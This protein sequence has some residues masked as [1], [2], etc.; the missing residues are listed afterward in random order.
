L[1]TIGASI[2]IALTFTVHEI[3]TGN[4]IDAFRG[5]FTRNANARSSFQLRFMLFRAA[6]A[7]EADL[8]KRAVQLYST[9]QQDE[10]HFFEGF[11]RSI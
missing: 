2:I 5:R 8:G 9:I 1:T 4:D 3:F 10:R 7:A 6:G 11:L